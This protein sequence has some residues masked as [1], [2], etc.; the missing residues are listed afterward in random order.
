M[1]TPL[2]DLPTPS[3]DTPLQVSP[4]VRDL[5][6]ELVG[7]AS[8]SWRRL[9]ACRPWP[10]SWWLPDGEGKPN[11]RSPEAKRAVQICEGCV[12]RD[13]CYALAM[14]TEY[15]GQRYGIYGATTPAERDREGWPTPGER[16]AARTAGQARAHRVRS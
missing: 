13:D 4:G 10:A 11:Y 9:A 3:V 5:L 8:L 14:N 1:T 6:L 16:R 7:A 15:Q 12:V 2:P